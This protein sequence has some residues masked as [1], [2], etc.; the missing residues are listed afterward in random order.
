MAD[1]RDGA[2]RLT[3]AGVLMCTT[4]PQRWLP[5]ACIRAA[6]YAADRIDRD[7]RTDMRVILG[8]LDKQVS[9]ALR[10]A[11]RNMLISAMKTTARSEKP[12]F[13]ERAVFEALVN[14]VAHRDYSMPA[15]RIRLDLF[16]DRLEFHVPGAL[17]GTMTPDSLHLKQATRIELVVSLLARCPAPTGLGGRTRRMDRRGDGVPIIRAECE[18]LFG[19]LPEYSLLDESEPRLIIRAAS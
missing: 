19:H 12:Q 5:G 15:A 1:D 18:Y 6:S 10:F 8:P 9:E 7:S 13:S 2:E 11:R 4:E 16:A 14:A 3:I 17:A